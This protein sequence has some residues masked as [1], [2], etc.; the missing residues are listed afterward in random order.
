MKVITEK[1]ARFACNVINEIDGIIS[2]V[3]KK[4]LIDLIEGNIKEIDTLTVSK[5]RPMYDAPKTG[6]DILCV[7][8]GSQEMYVAFYNKD[9]WEIPGA[10]IFLED[11]S[12]VGWLPMP[13]YKPE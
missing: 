2:K 8:H 13:I 1:D 12:I 4:H 5:L 9:K 11:D 6:G 3:V 10:E 7:M